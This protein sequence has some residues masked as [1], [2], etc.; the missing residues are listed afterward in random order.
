MSVVRLGL[1]LFGALLT[2]SALAQSDYKRQLESL[3]P[4][5][6]KGYFLLAEDIAG[7]SRGVE[8]VQLARR[9]YVL[10]F[11]LAQKGRAIDPDNPE[12]SDFPIA[13]SA[14]LGLADLESTEDRKRWLWALAGRLDERYAA[15]RWDSSNQSDTPNEAALLLSEAIGL[16]LSGDGSLARERF[17]DPRVITLLEQTRDLLDR[18]GNEASSSA[19]R[20]DAEV[21]PCPEC[22]NARGV[23]DRSEGGQVRRLCSTCRGNPGPVISRDAFVA[24]LAYQSALLHGTQKSWSAELVVGRG[25]TLLDPE[26]SEVAPSMGVDPTKVHYRDGKWLDDRELMEL[27]EEA[28]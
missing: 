19:I 15:R 18:P 21:W 28:E 5:D 25:R 20:R 11:V 17:D 7:Q 8:D 1:V 9:L 27:Q 12:G 10:A 14:C 4:S 3:A 26:P 16:A 6:P 23:P 13:A 2:T 24:Y 22:G